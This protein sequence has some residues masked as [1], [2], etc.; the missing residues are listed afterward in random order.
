MRERGIARDLWP[1][2]QRI[3]ED[4]GFTRVTRV[5]M[6]IGSSHGA[7]AELLEHGFEDIFD[8]SPFAGAVVSVHVV[9]PGESFCHPIAEEAQTANGWEVLI[10]DMVGEP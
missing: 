5:E 3:A 6:T 9:E 7:L 4:Y 8:G 1:Q 2:L 10:T